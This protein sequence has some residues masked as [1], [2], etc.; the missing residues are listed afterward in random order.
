MWP[1]T[2]SQNPNWAKMRKAIANRCLRYVR[3]A[4]LSVKI[5]GE[6]DSSATNARA[7]SPLPKAL[8]GLAVTGEGG[9]TAEG[10]ILDVGI[11][12]DGGSFG[13][14]SRNRWKIGTW[15]RRWRFIG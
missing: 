12:D 9:V 5:G 3:S 8:V 6:V 7:G 2:P 14:L 4:Y 1:A 15:W 13:W 10:A 11:E